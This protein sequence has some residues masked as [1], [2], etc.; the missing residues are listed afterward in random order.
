MKQCTVFF[1]AT[2]AGVF[3]DDSVGMYHCR[4]IIGFDVVGIV[5]FVLFNGS[6]NSETTWG[7]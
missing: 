2:D 6:P 7:A 5:P 4:F 3:I 1:E